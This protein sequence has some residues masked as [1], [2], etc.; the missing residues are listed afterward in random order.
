M[1][2]KCIKCDYTTLKKYSFNTHMSRTHGT[3]PH[4]CDIC[5]YATNFKHYLKIH[6]N[7]LHLNVF[8]HSCQL[9]EFKTNDTSHLQDHQARN[10]GSG[11]VTCNMCGYKAGFE[12]GLA[13]HIKMVHQK[14]K[15][16]MCMNCDMCFSTRCELRS[17][18]IGKHTNNRSYKCG[19][20]EYSAKFKTHLNGHIRRR[21]M[22]TK[23]QLQCSIPRCNFRT[24]CQENV[25]KHVKNMQISRS[26]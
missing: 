11:G 7:S 19:E 24:N 26:G 13:D 21:H 5:D 25:K 4:Q 2:Y 3:K 8:K 17:H 9:C 10:H 23:D 15:S 22:S 14:E 6:I 12:P 18:V 16:I 1:Q 20:C